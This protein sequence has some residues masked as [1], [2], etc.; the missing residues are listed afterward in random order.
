MSETNNTTT[1]ASSSTEQLPYTWTQTL[2]DCTLTVPIDTGIKGRDILVDFKKEHLIVKIKPGNK[3]IIDGK[4]HK[5]IKVG[6]STWSIEESK[7]GK[8]MVIELVKVNQMEWWS[9]I[10]VGHSQIDTSK[11][12]PENS[13]ISDLDGETRGMVEKM[14]FDQRQKQMGLPTS[15]ELQKQE[16][17]KKFMA[18]HPEMDFSQTKF[19]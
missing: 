19:Q 18:Q 7:N 6:D 4:L 11:I 16:M 2:Q 1:E 3:T 13:K 12:E 10:I 14:M 17:M 8:A 5:S 15:D 9:C